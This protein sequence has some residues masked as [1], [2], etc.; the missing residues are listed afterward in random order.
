MNRQKLFRELL[1]FRQDALFDSKVQKSHVRVARTQRL[2][3]HTIFSLDTEIFKLL[4]YCYW[5]RK[6]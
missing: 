3:G 1:C 2:R 4:N 6:L 5:V